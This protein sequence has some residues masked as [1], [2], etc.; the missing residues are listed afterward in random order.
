L[1]GLEPPADFEGAAR[2]LKGDPRVLSAVREGDQLI[3]ELTPGEHGHHFMLDTLMK[4]GHKIAAFTPQQIK[5]EDAFL[6]L[7]K[8]ALQ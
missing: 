5:L 3:V 1:I 4:G 2:S 7:T 8:G 6:K